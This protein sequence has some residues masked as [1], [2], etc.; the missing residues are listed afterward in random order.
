MVHL[1]LEWIIQQNMGKRQQAP[2]D[3]KKY[4]LDRPRSQWVIF[5]SFFKIYL[6]V[7]HHLHTQQNKTYAECYI[8]K[9]LAFPHL[10][11]SIE[12]LSLKLDVFPV[13]GWHCCLFHHLGVVVIFH[14]I[15]LIERHL[16]RTKPGNNCRRTFCDSLPISGASTLSPGSIATVLSLCY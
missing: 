11:E 12:H 5:F 4:H 15:S 3:D 6:K 10:V 8:A 7:V 16:Q 9:L 1:C 2:H 13:K 14:G